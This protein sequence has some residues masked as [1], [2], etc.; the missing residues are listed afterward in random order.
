MS[1]CY[2]GLPFWTADQRCH[3][4]SLLIFNF[5]LVSPEIQ[6]YIGNSLLY[7][8]FFLHMTLFSLPLHIPP[9]PTF[10]LSLYF[11]NFP[12]YL[13]LSFTFSPSYSILCH[14]LFIP[15]T[16]SFYL[17][18]L[19]CLFPFSVF[20]SV[21]VGVWKTLCLSP[22]RKV[23]LH[24]PSSLLIRNKRQCETSPRHTHWHSKHLSYIHSM[25]WRL[26]Q[27]SRMK[28]HKKTGRGREGDRKREQISL[29]Y[30]EREERIKCVWVCEREEIS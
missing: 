25:A 28:G 1:Q 10:R 20:L 5:S 21:S 27:C 16:L 29:E 18:F 26:K 15:L 17:Y 11:S 7:I 19:L 3:H 22:E 14:S 8:S 12:D 13:H 24:S 4:I 30:W 9:L 2:L 6:Q 23:L